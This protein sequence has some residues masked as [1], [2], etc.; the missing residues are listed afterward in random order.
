MT[1]PELAGDYNNVLHIYTRLSQN[2]L[3]S[4]FR[5]NSPAARQI[6]SIGV[7]GLTLAGVGLFGFMTYTVSC[8]T[9]EIGIRLALGA[10]SGRVQRLIIGQGMTLVMTATGTGFGGAWITDVAGVEVGQTTII[11]GENIV[12]E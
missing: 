3:R 8:R 2:L 12:P 10:E 9:R 6:E 4:I 7:I 1:R 11:R 5:G